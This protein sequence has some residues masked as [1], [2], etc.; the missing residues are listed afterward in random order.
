MMSSTL[1]HWLRLWETVKTWTRNKKFD[2]VP[3][4][5]G[6]T[7]CLWKG[8]ENY[9]PPKKIGLQS[10]ESATTLHPV[11]RLPRARDGES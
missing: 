10:L 11:H 2:K 4:S 7:S 3:D 6:E 5:P 9:D 1:R 8:D